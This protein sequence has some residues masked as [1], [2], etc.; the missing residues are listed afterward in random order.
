M[1]EFRLTADKNNELENSNTATTGAARALS[2]DRSRRL[3]YGAGALAL[4]L[5]VRLYLF[6]GEYTINGDGIRYVAAAG[7][8]GRGRGAEGL[9]SFSPPFFPL[10][11]AAAYPIAGNWEL[12][13]R[14]WPL[15]LGSLMLLPI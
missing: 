6:A 13:G 10:L 3:L 2:S 14:L 9:S 8:F 7:I 11:I 12:A 4:A 15:L 1:S 5:A